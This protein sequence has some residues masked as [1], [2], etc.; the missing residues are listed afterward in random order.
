MGR[1]EGRVVLTEQPDSRRAV[2]YWSKLKERLKDEGTEQLL[3]NC[4]QLKMVA[5]DG[6][7]RLT[8]VMDVE[9]IFRLIQSIPSKKA[10]YL[11]F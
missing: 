5:N 2:F 4:Q 3:T 6:K 10:E 1:G 9:Q 8:D 7:L 11:T